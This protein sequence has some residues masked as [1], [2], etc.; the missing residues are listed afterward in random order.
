MRPDRKRLL[1]LE[2]LESLLLAAQRVSDKY[3]HDN[4]G[5]PSDWSEWS[6]LRFQVRQARAALAREG[7]S[8]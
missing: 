2:A 5:V 1:T 7:V 4:R 6:D 3:G 8:A